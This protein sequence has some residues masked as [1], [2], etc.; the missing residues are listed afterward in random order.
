MSRLAVFIFAL[1][2]APAVRAEVTPGEILIAEMNCTACHDAGPLTARLASRQSPRLGHDGV[3]AKAEWVR[4]FLLDPQKTKPGTLMPDALHALPPEQKASAAE[5]LTHFLL[6]QQTPEAAPARRAEAAKITTG[7][8]L[9]HAVG[10]AMCHAPFRPPVGKENDA[11]AK[12]ELVRLQQYS[13]PLGEGIALKY[14]LA[15]LTRFLRD[16]LK[17]R[18]SGRMPAMNL[19]E[20]EAESI[21]AYLLRDQAAPS[22]PFTVD[23]TLAA[24]GQ[25][26]FTDMNCAA[27]HEGIAS[28]KR[29]AKPLAQIAA[30]QP[31]G[32]L[33]ARPGPNVPKFEISDRQR[34]V[35]LALLQERTPLN[36]PLTP[37]HAL[38][39]TLTALNCYACHTRDRRGGVDGLRREYFTSTTSVELGDEGRI[40]PTLTHI[41]AKLRPDWMKTLLEQG[42]N[43]RPYMATRMPVFG[44]ANIAH[45]PGLFEKADVRT[46]EVPPPAATDEA[47]VHGRKLISSSGLNCTACHSFSGQP[48]AGPPGTD[49]ATAP[50]RLKWDWFR[51]FLLDPQATRPGTRMPAFWPGGAAQNKEVLGGDLEKQI[52]AIWACLAGE[53]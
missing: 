30:R 33:S 15:E 29:A 23:A 20:A 34:Q 13:V 16:P 8:Q 46:D 1:I 41:G 28:P 44:T 2:V 4:A 43:T 6:S 19:S 11:T 35:I 24:N 49:L 18:P 53:K 25:Q 12:D 47:S 48:S 26:L 38:R 27:C 21:A 5:A 17:A 14:T 37:E 36:T 52:A 3:R 31:R 50:Q 22:P 32:C 7:E 40:P 42:A 45:L 39:R 9:Y 10:C 51:R